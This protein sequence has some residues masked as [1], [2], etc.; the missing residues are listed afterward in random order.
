MHIDIFLS[1][2]MFISS[3]CKHAKVHALLQRTR[4]QA[5]QYIRRRCRTR[6]S[7][8]RADTRS[9]RAR[10]PLF[11]AN[12]AHAA[13]VINYSL[14]RVRLWAACTERLARFPFRSARI[15]RYTICRSRRRKYGQIFA[16]NKAYGGDKYLSDVTDPSDVYSMRDQLILRKKGK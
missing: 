16:A 13:R 4:A 12:L 11:Y 2:Q 7:E 9:I 14:G 1:I 6:E 15:L 5:S 8:C 10:K 3:R